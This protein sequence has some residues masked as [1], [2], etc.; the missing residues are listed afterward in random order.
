MLLVLSPLLLLLLLT[1]HG[2]L[3]AKAWTHGVVSKLPPAVSPARSQHNPAAMHD[4]I[5]AI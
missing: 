3:H 5:S 4:T 1:G 2:N